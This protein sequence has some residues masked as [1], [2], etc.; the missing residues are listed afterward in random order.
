MR[1]KMSGN[2]GERRRE[3]LLLVRGEER[4]CRCEKRRDEGAKKYGKQE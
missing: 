4:E 1:K 2:D 3:G